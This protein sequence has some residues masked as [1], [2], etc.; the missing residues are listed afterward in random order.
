MQHP[1][2]QT[3]DLPLLEAVRT[4]FVDSGPDWK[5]WIGTLRTAGAAGPPPPEES[6]FSDIM[7]K[8]L[9][10][11]A[12][13]SRREERRG[14]TGSRRYDALNDNPGQLRRSTDDPV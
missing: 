9:L 2:P 4:R 14:A 11:R 13:L 8:S 1:A 5:S 12:G 7:G 10:D 3:D 6:E